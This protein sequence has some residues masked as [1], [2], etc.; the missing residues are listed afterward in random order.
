MSRTVR[1][2]GALARERKWL[3][4][5]GAGAL[6]LACG[7]RPDAAAPRGA[8]AYRTGSSSRPAPVSPSA[9]AA[10]DPGPDRAPAPPA[11]PRA[12][13]PGEPRPARDHGV[14]PAAADTVAVAAED[15]VH[16]GAAVDEVVAAGADQEVPA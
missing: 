5:V 3:S 14:V 12:R 9:A 15:R 8:D 2:V 7:A 11:G 10:S 16:P 6:L 4:I 13:A 1:A